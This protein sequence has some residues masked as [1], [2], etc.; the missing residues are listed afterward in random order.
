LSIRCWNLWMDWWLLYCQ[1]YLWFFKQYQRSAL[2]C[3]VIPSRNSNRFWSLQSCP[4]TIISLS[5]KQR[6]W[7]GHQNSQQR[8]S[9][10]Y[11]S[12]SHVNF[13]TNPYDAFN[14]NGIDNLRCTL[15]LFI[16]AFVIS[17]YCYLCP[18]NLLHNWMES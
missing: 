11:I 3:Y 4:K 18:R 13:S 9:I 2:H 10:I 7:K 15:F 1:I 8:L 12:Y 6:N 17:I 5:F 16:Y 14:I